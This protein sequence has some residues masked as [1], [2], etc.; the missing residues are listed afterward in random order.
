[1]NGEYIMDSFLDWYFSDD[2]IW[3][4]ANK[5]YVYNDTKESE[6]QG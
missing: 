2:Y 1:M 3:D 6:V 5:E 4:E